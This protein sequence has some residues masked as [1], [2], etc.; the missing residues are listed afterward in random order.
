LRR[1]PAG[2]RG[3]AARAWVSRG[4]APGPRASVLELIAE[5][6]TAKEMADRLHVAVPS[7]KSH[8][9]SLYMK[10]GV[11]GRGAGDRRGL[12]D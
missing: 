9:Q 7:A 8:I 2:T 12:I 10:L 11:N 5:G 3:D 1:T 4:E 6:L